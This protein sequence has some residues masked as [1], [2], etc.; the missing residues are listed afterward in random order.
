MALSF[1]WSAIT[2][3]VKKIMRAWRLVVAVVLL[4]LVMVAGCDVRPFSEFSGDDNGSENSDDT[5]GDDTNEPD[6]DEP[7]DTLTVTPT[8]LT[9][10]V[11]TMETINLNVVDPETGRTYTFD[12]TTDPE[13]G[14]A[15]IDEFDDDTGRLTYTPDTAFTG[16]DSLEVT[17]MANGTPARS[18]TITIQ[19]TVT[20]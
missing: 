12:I 18:G 19:I 5:D 2:D 3:S 11:N 1:L 4:S 8:T 16:P 9:T 6:D 15:E 17:V 10:S 7:D 13:N 14:N 20:Q